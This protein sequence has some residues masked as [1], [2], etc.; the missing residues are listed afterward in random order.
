[1]EYKDYYKILGVERSASADEIKKAYRKLARKYH[2]DVS[3]E[4]DAEE[5]FKTVNEAYE[6][7]HDKEK[8]QAYDTLG[9]SWRQGQDFRPPPGWDGQ[10][11]EGFGQGFN[12]GGS[13]FSDFF[14][15]LFGGG[16]GG[17]F[18]SHGF[19]G[20]AQHSQVQDQQY[21]LAVSLEDVIQGA[22]KR[23][24]L[25]VR[26][27]TSDGRVMQTDKTLEVKI[28]V[29]VK[30]GQVIRLAGQADAA[31]GR[32]AGNVLLEIEYQAH[33]RYQVEGADLYADIRLAPW[34]AALG[35][36]VDF[37]TPTGKTQL[38]IPAN[39]RAGQKLRLRGKGLPAG[40]SGETAGDLYAV[41]QIVLPPADSDEVKNAYQELARVSGFSA[42][43]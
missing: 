11:F 18:R 8:R 10:G 39:A 13:G 16:M 23:I 36:K 28:P 14:E 21:R 24:T 3:K 4:P 35:A 27:V 17:G 7:L 29:G 40:K 32:R 15:T 41:I 9:S 1:M 2:P 38:S 37:E 43:G 31:P 5:R 19:G 22:V 12:R 26:N 20:G 6:V 25:P 42:R 34:E 30:A 33:P